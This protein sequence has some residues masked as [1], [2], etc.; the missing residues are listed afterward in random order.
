VSNYFPVHRGW[1]NDWCRLRIERHRTRLDLPDF[2]YFFNF[3][4]GAFGTLSSTVFYWLHVTHGINWPLSL[5][6][7][8]P[9]AWD[10]IGIWTGNVSPVDWPERKRHIRRPRQLEIVVTIESRGFHLVRVQCTSIPRLPSQPKASKSVTPT[11][12]E[13]V[14]H[15]WRVG[16]SGRVAL[17]SS[18]GARVSVS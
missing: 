12:R 2:R 17:R 6:L 11:S 1:H 14:D 7:Q 16:R 8:C 5:V 3:A 13:P 4:L 10:W 18:C 15:R 9:R